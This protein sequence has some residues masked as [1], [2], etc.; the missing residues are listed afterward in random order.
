MSSQFLFLLLAKCCT[1]LYQSEQPDLSFSFAVGECRVDER[2]QYMPRQRKPATQV[3]DV[4]VCACAPM[5]F[6]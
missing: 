2:L 6:R 5:R 1:D 4:I 3:Q